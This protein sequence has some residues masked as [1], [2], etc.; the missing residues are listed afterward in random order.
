MTHFW[1]NLHQVCSR[2][3]YLKAKSF[4]GLLVCSRPKYLKAKSFKG[5]FRSKKTKGP[6]QDCQNQLR[7]PMPEGGE[8]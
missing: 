8:P 2:P 4:K 6:K 3:K 1:N 5:L 7:P